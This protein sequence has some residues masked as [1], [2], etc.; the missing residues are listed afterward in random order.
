LETDSLPD[1]WKG[2]KVRIRVW[3]TFRRARP[4]VSASAATPRLFL[5]PGKWSGE[6]WQDLDNDSKVGVGNLQRGLKAEPWCFLPPFEIAMGDS[7]R[8][9]P[10]CRIRIPKPVTDT[11]TLKRANP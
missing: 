10:D 8:L 4:R 9:A 3:P 7:L 6:I 5:A 2:A 1:G 11:T